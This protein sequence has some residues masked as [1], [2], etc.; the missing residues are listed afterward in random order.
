M[1]YY[2][3]H[4]RIYPKTTNFCVIVE[5]DN[6]MAGKGQITS[7]RASSGRKRDGDV[8]ENTQGNFRSRMR[9]PNGTPKASRDLRSLPVAMV[10]VLLYY[11]L[12]YYYSKKQAREC[13]A[14]AQ[15]ILSVTSVPVA[16]P[17]I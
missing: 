1:E 3:Q 5:G 10:L 2:T 14:H 12:Y 4:P 11:N 6:K 9:I 13:V 15:N 16:P 7:E 17:Q 8:L